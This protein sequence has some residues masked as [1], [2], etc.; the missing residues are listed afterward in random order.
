MAKKVEAKKSETK[1]ASLKIKK[2]KLEKLYEKKPLVEFVVAILSIPSIILL[3][4]LN[5]KSLSN[6]N[7]AKLTPTPASSATLP[8][9][10]RH[11]FSRPVST[12]PTPTTEVAITQTQSPCNTGLGPV[13]ITSP[14]QG[15]TVSSNPVE[16]DISYDTSTYCSAV[17]SY[18]ING[19]GWS[20]YNNNSVALYNLPNG[21]IQF[22]LRVKSL[23]SSDT[24]TL[25]RNF[26]YNGQSNMPEPTTASGSAN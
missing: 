5:F 13:S 18:S 15:D 24:T 20:D 8:V 10:N 7:N 2:K 3:L 16:V 19:S 11:F 23:T 1:A 25:T 26:N 12:A 21:Q 22:Q 9:T 14:N 17:W 4:I 6:V